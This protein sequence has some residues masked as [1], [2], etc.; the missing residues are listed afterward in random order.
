[1][2]VNEDCFGCGH[3]VHSWLV[4]LVNQLSVVRQLINR[5]LADTNRSV[6]IVLQWHDLEPAGER[7]ASRAGRVLDDDL[8]AVVRRGWRGAVSVHRRLGEPSAGLEWV[9]SAESATIS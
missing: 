8:V 1:L 6:T 3:S 5:D 2:K 9:P 7:V 4:V